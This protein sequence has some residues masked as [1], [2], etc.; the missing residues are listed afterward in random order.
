MRNSTATQVNT[1]KA[2]NAVGSI[3]AGC[4][5][6]VPASQQYQH[7]G[8]R[9]TGTGHGW[10][11]IPGRVAL[12]QHQPGDKMAAPAVLISGPGSTDQCPCRFSRP[13]PPSAH[14]SKRRQAQQ[15]EHPM[16]ST[17][18]NASRRAARQAHATFSQVDR[19]DHR[20]ECIRHRAGSRP[21][22]V[23]PAPHDHGASVPTVKAH[24]L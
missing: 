19:D 9:H 10:R 4:A 6:L 14:G 17:S 7:A 24:E 18:S 20:A 15:F 21:P 12:P 2:V 23:L 22:T 11:T 13:T 5:R 8:G 16:A 3:V 1:T